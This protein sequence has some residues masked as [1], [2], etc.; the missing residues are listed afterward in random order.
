MAL[1]TLLLQSTS[2]FVRIIVHHEHYFPNTVKYPFRTNRVETIYKDQEKEIF[3]VTDRTASPNSNLVEI[4][5]AFVTRLPL[6]NY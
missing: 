1:W 3:T 2:N 5:L 6:E 4:C